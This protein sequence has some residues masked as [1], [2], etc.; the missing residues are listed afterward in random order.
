[1]AI[2]SFGRLKDHKCFPTYCVLI[3]FGGNFPKTMTS[4]NMG[5]GDGGSVQVCPTSSLLGPLNVAYVVGVW[6]ISLL[7]ELCDSCIFK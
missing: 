1:L 2:V 5:L 6:G 7:L 4:F 3:V